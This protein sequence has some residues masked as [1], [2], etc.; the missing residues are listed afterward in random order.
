MSEQNGVY[1]ALVKAQAEFPA[2]SKD[3]SVKVT[4]KSG[5]SYTF[6]YAPLDSILAKVGPVL[7]AN[8]LA[9][10]Q[11][12]GVS[13]TGSPTLN[14]ALVHTDG[15]TISGDL[16]L[17]V[18]Q[19]ASAQELGS[20]IT[21]CRRYA[22][23]AILGLATEEDDDANH[24]SGNTVQ[25]RQVASQSVGDGQETDPHGLAESRGDSVAPGQVIVGFGKHKGTMVKD[26]PR[27]YWEWW[28]GQDGRKDETILAA[29]EA[30]LGVQPV[31]AAGGANYDDDIPFAPSEA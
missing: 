20:L 15:S 1:A 18:H 24:A 9:I 2:I 30:H 3:K 4:A 27:S 23:V 28:L 22:I 8:G 6:K 13:P 14:T 31:P 19:G 5:A 21:Y 29:V 25:A 7:A 16:P 17:P 10:T 12:F 11:T 26:V